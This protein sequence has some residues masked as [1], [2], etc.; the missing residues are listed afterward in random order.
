MITPEA[1]AP[2]YVISPD[3]VRIATYEFGDSEA[4]TVLAVHGFASSALVNWHATGWVRD[5]LRAGFHVIAVDQRG[6]GASHKPQRPDA[7]SMELLVADVLQVLDTFMLDEVD[8]V[9]YSLGARVGWQAANTLPTRIRRTVLGGIPDGEPLT[10][11]RVDQARVF[12]SD[13]TPVEDRLTGAYL[14]MAGAIPGNDLGALVSLVE[15][16]RGSPQ[17]GTGNAPVQQTLFATG[18]ED[19]ILEASRRL[20]AATPSGSFF[21]IPGRNHFNAPTS[22]A[23]RDAAIRFLGVGSLT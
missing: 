9:G 8:Y 10:R 5:L 16:M 7:Y 13:T 21:E 12:L 22:R 23:F 6:H 17:P 14:T 20:A 11:F 1:P 15:G 18:S 4:P 19:G 2:R 3:N